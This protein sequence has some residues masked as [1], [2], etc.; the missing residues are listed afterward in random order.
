MPAAARRCRRSSRPSR[1]SPRASSRRDRQVDVARGRRRSRA[2]GRCRRWR[3]TWRNRSA[4]SSVASPPRP[5][6]DS[7]PS[8][9]RRASAATNDQIHGWRPASADGSHA[10]SRP[11]PLE[12]A[13]VPST[14][15]RIAPCTLSCQSVET[16]MNDSSEPGQQHDQRADHGARPATRCRRRTRR[17]RRSPRRSRAACSA[18][19]WWRRRVVF[20]PV[21]SRPAI[22]PNMPASPYSALRAAE[23]RPA[24]ALHRARRAADAA[25]HHAVGGAHEQPV[26]DQRASS[27]ER[28]RSAAARTAGAGDE[29][30][31]AT[32]A[33]RRPASAA[34]ATARPSQTKEAPSVTT[35]DGSRRSW[36]N[37]PIPA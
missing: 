33:T 5:S 28:P 10:R 7:R 16:S 3:R 25:Q 17:R 13:R 2:S 32:Q 15:I 11:P 27:D 37:A 34:P 21:S 29:R 24:G 12:G 20:S 14:R 9:A 30:A 36:M 22:T 1:D 23:Q 4:P 6:H 19:R 8:A 18:R 35:I 31:A 26:T